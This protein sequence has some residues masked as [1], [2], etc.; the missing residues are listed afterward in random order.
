MR[1]LFRVLEATVRKLAFPMSDGEPLEHFGDQSGFVE[2]QSSSFLQSSFR[3]AF[4]LFF[5]C[6]LVFI[7][8]IVPREN[9]SAGPCFSST[10]NNYA[11]I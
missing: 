10:S 11:S 1:T 9:V 5:V 3:L 7:H 6:C 8:V 4:T 2:I